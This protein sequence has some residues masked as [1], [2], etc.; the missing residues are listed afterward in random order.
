M[1]SRALSA[2][3][4]ALR[5][6][7]AVAPVRL[8]AVSAARSVTTDAASA[9][10]ST[11]VPQSDD[12]HFLVNLS[13]ESFETYELDPP[14]YTIEVT[15]KELKQ[16]YYDMVSIRYERAKYMAAPRESNPTGDHG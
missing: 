9:S 1:F 10:L 3:R 16:M 2:P 14:S 7:A 4:V 13:D 5:R 12:E 15:K 11:T 6:A 8:G